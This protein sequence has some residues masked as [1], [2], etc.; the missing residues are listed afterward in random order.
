MKARVGILAGL[1][2]A[3]VGVYALGWATG[4]SHGH[5]QPVP[6]AVQAPITPPC[7]S[8]IQGNWEWFNDDGTCEVT[9]TINGVTFGYVQNTEGQTLV[10]WEIGDGDVCGNAGLDASTS[11][12]GWF[13]DVDCSV[14][15]PPR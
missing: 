14:R 8:G 5:T 7:P 15:R 12:P 9:T 6:A 2:I 4:A 1:V 3:G 13:A 10:T 11:H